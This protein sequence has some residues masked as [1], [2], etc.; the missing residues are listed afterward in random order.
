MSDA[1]RD[2][3][4]QIQRQ[5]TSGRKLPAA[6]INQQS[7]LMPVPA[8]YLW[9]NDPLA[10]SI[11]AATLSKKNKTILRKIIKSQHYVNE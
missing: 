3:K 2:H 1:L 8:D 7:H 11:Q 9:C 5:K 10:I 4:K 6:E